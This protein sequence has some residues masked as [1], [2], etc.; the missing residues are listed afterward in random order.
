MLPPGKK[1]PAALIVDVE[2]KPSRKGGMDPMT[3]MGDGQDDDYNTDSTASMEAFMD[4]IH[5]NDS[6]GAVEA[7]KTLM[8]VC[9]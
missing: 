5:A 9:G 2:D 4:A 3:D 6:A 7:F 1:S 8:T